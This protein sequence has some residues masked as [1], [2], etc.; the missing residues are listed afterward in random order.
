[1]LVPDHIAL[2]L[3]AEQSI[4]PLLLGASQSAVEFAANLRAVAWVLQDDM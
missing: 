2:R 4:G 1:M 3:L